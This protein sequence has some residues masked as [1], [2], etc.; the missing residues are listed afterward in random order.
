MTTLLATEIKIEKMDNA[1]WRIAVYVEGRLHD[2]AE[3]F[4]SLESAMAAA[5]DFVK[6]VKSM[7]GVEEV[8]LH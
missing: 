1:T 2:A 6:I 5:D 7:A 8:D 3:G 4:S